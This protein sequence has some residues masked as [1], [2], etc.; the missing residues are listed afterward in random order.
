MAVVS[1]FGAA[2]RTR[3]FPAGLAFTAFAAYRALG[4]P[5]LLPREDRAELAAGA[6]R[7]LAS[8]PQVALRGTYDISGYRADANL[9][10]WLA[11]PS[12]DQ[13]QDALAAFGQTPLA[14]ALESVWSAI[15]V[16]RATDPLAKANP[17]A[18]YLGESARRY[19]CVNPVSYS[20]DWH[21]LD[22]QQRRRVQADT[23]RQMRNYPDVRSNGVTTVG[24]GDYEAILAY[25][26]EDMIRLVDLLR[27][28]TVA[29]T[30]RFISGE[31]TYITGARKPLVDIVDSLP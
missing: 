23:E 22:T 20:A 10:L 14:L 30:R 26:G 8:T 7:T 13:L 3:S 17:P 21:H 1:S 29:P 5:T 9:L 4:T 12:P 18:Y 6:L 19:V 2:E 28:L 27:E 16:H 31:Q 15:G 24:L 25:E 11:A